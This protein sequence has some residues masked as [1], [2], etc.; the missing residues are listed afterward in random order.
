[1][2]GAARVDV[3]PRTLPA[4]CN[5]GF[6]ER[7]FDR[8]LD[9]LMARA[10]VLDD[11]ATRIALV[12]V[13]SCMIPR[14]VCERTKQLA[15]KQTGIPVERMLIAATHTH[16]APS[17]MDYCLGSRADTPYTELLPAR[18]AEAIQQASANLQ[19]AELGQA[20]IDAPE[21]THCRRWIVK[22][23]KIG[24]DPFGERTVRAMMHPGYQ[25]SD[26]AGPAGP[27]D[28]ELTVVAIRALDQRPIALLANYSMHYFGAGGG[29]SADY[30]GRFCEAV[31]TAIGQ[32]AGDG[33]ARPLA[34]MSQG[35]SGDLHWMDYS[36]PKQPITI[37]QYAGEVAALALQAHARIEYRRD[38]PLAMVERTL[39]LGR[40]TPSPERLEWAK[41]L[42]EA[43]GDRRP[44]D[45]P[46]V[47]AEQAVYLHEH[48]TEQVVLQAV[49]IGELAITAIPCEVYGV[50]GLKLKTHSPLEATFNMELANGASGYIPTPEQHRLGGYTTWPSRTAGLEVE[51]EPKIVAELVSMLEEV[52]G[53]PRR[54]LTDDLYTPEM[55]ARMEAVLEE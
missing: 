24:I 8:V 32:S 54:A 2:A 10:I 39:V 12:V 22:P 34:I 47:Y 38:V 48:P 5:G 13:D 30:F 51:A 46:E 52:T 31:E 29:F 28:T 45:R 37:D 40:R 7:T 14:E 20:S 27:V 18:I 44:K 4:I 16:T 1:M 26:Y 35:T 17:V 9:P 6:I 49:R 43:R 50:T 42:N 21:H 23:D 3:S 33:G 15:N 53:K 55:R 41:K 19:P 36:R 25:N 11:G